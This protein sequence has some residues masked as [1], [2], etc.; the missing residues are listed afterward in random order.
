MRT[1]LPGNPLTSLGETLRR[2]HA[3]RVP[4][5][6]LCERLRAAGDDP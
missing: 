3:D 5:D 6:A 4:M 2:F 1:M